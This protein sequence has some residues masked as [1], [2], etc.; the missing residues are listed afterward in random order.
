MI[1]IVGQMCSG[2]T[3]F[4]KIFKELGLNVF[5]LDHIRTDIPLTEAYKEALKSDII[6]GYTPFRIREHWEAIEPHLKNVKY[7]LLTPIYEKWKENCKP[8]IACP[9]DENP[10]DYTK[11]EYE[12]ENNRLKYLIKP[13]ITI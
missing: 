12:A 10:P 5:H 11:E 1:W 7:I 4:S 8:I 13:I 9:T 6:E 2:K 3:T